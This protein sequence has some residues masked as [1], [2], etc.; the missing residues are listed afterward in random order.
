L[1]KLPFI[2]IRDTSFPS[3]YF[4]LHTVS[5]DIFN[6]ITLPVIKYVWYHPDSQ[7]YYNAVMFASVGFGLPVFSIQIYP[8][9]LIYFC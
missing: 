2:H 4:S 1:N 8:R 7:R 9:Q 3:T 5:T 6:I